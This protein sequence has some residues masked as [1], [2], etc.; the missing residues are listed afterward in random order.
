[1]SKPYKVLALFAYF[2]LGL[3]PPF[4]SIVAL[5]SNEFDGLEKLALA[6]SF[7]IAFPLSLAQ[8]SNFE[9]EFPRTSLGVLK[10]I[11]LPVI[12]ILL[13]AY[14]LKLSFLS[15]FLIL[16]IFLLGSRLFAQIFSSSQEFIKEKN[17]KDLASISLL[18]PLMAMP[19]G[20]Y[21]YHSINQLWD[22]YPPSQGWFYVFLTGLLVVIVKEVS[23]Y[24][25]IYKN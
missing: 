6:I 11:L 2:W 7:P 1:M 20:V 19:L 8:L 18:F 13:Q 3:V 15:G 10:L 21:F 16:N 24:V 9:E 5:S 14:L 17:W 4:A 25:K 22:A 23:L 12:L